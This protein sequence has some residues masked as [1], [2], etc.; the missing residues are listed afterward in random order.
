MNAFTDNFIAKDYYDLSL[1]IENAISNQTDI[2]TK[3]KDA[4]LLRSAISRY[5]YAT[6]LSLREEFKKV[7]N[8]QSKIKNNST[9][10]GNIIREMKRL[11]TG[12]YYLAGFLDDLRSE[13]NNSDYKLPSIYNVN[14]TK[15]NMANRKALEILNNLQTIIQSL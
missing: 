6:F 12:L 10:H 4:G 5:Y 15:V 7:P 9:D 1:E 11:P 3:S 14:P 13:R 8:L 2:Q